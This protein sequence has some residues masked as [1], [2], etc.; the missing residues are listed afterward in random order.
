M[1]IYHLTAV[2]RTRV[3]VRGK[4][5]KYVF[6]TLVFAIMHPLLFAINLRSLCKFVKF[7]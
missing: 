1:S 6:P 4:H 2:A 5:H 7:F 3:K